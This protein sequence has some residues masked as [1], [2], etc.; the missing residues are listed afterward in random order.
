MAKGYQFDG[1][2]LIINAKALSEAQAA[3]GKGS[4]YWFAQTEG[5]SATRRP[6]SKKMSACV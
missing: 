2:D 3:A 5:L 6:T 4:L 1:K